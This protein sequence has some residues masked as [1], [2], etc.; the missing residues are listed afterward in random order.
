MTWHDQWG[1]GV[2]GVFVMV[3]FMLL[4]WGAIIAL[5][6]WAV[7]Q[8]RP[9]G[10]PPPPAHGGDPAMRILEERFARGEIDADEFTRRRDILR[11]GPAG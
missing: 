8:F 5:V 2:G 10:P 1:W 6:V 11:G 3:V 4:F 9:P 7:R